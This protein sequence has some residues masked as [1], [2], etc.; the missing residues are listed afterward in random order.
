[1]SRP[2]LEL[3]GL[4]VSRGGQ[5][6]LHG[7]DLSVC[8]GELMALLGPSGCGKSTLLKAVTGLLEPGSGDVLIDGASVL[9]LPTEKR[10]AVI[11]FQDLRLFPHLSVEGNIEFPMKLLGVPRSERA[12][13][14]K[15]LLETVRLPGTEKRRVDQLSGGQ[16]QRVALARA[17][18]ARPRLLLLDEP[19]SSLDEEL[20]CEMDDFVKELHRRSDITI[21]MVTHD[22]REAL[23][24][25][26]R[27]AL[28]IDGRLAQVDTPE[29]IYLRPASRSVSDYWGGCSYISGHVKAGIFSSPAID[30]P[31]QGCSDGGWTACVRPN[32]VRLLDHG[33]WEV[34][35]LRYQGESSLITLSLKGSELAARTQEPVRLGDMLGVELDSNKLVFFPAEQAGCTEQ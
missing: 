15:R 5:E 20:R 7:I 21:V 29:E 22:K 3:R 23:S 33:E 25:S 26:D 28:M 35:N 9:R 24:I 8:R 14:V 31:V 10:G 19:F 32:A 11:V 30:I 2:M 1:M 34:V 16:M 6:I 13:Q 27:I 17:L 18:A 4:S 12:A